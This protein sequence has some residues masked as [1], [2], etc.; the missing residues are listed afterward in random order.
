MKFLTRRRNHKYQKADTDFPCRTE[1]TKIVNYPDLNNTLLHTDKIKAIFKALEFSLT[2]HLAWFKPDLEDSKY[3]NIFPGEHYRFINSLVRTLGIKKVVDI[4]TYTGLSTIACIE[5]NEAAFVDTFDVL[6]LESYPNHI[7]DNELILGKFKQHVVNLS[8][9]NIW[10]RYK[11]ILDDAQLIILDANKDVHTEKALIE[12][13]RTLSK[14]QFRLL[15]IDDIHFSNMQKLWYGINAPKL[16]ITAFA[17]WSG[18][19]IVDISDP[20]RL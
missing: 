11:S 17:H 20:S 4:G 8:S 6:G 16:D 1:L 18:S 5:N 15:L 2:N 12:K 7:F 13:F 19:G 9:L 3:V 14:R 10:E